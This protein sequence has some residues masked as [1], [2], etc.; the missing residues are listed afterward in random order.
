MNRNQEANDVFAHKPIRFFRGTCDGRR[1]DHG[2]VSAG[3]AE[4]YIYTGS[5]FESLG[6][7]GLTAGDRI[8]ATFTFDT[9][10]TDGG[11]FNSL[12]STAGL[13]SWTITDGNVE[14][15]SSDAGVDYELIILNNFEGTG[16]SGWEIDM[17]DSTDQL[18]TYAPS[19]FNSVCD[20][21]PCDF[22]ESQTEPGNIAYN[23]TTEGTWSEASLSGTP[24]PGSWTLIL[25]GCALLIAGRSRTV[26]TSVD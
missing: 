6:D 26:R 11:N 2:A 8:T 16:F 22:S 24:E 4:V 7:R 14:L 21:G 12:S 13:E 25:A 19:A 1:F 17:A 3:A 20:G 15:T 18:G 23:N 9:A 10:F 5:P